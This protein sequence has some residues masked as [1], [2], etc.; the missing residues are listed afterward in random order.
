MNPIFQT[1]NQSNATTQAND[2]SSLYK[3]F[4]SMGNPMAM[5]QQMAQRNP[6]LQPFVQML[7]SG[8]NPEQLCRMICQQRGIDANTFIQQ[9]QNSIR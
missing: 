9:I 3:Q 6:Q 7:N 2:I 4:M 1:V 8:A 5:F